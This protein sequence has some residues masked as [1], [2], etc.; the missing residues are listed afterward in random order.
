[1]RKLK[2]Q[3]Q[4][5][6]DGFVAGP[7]GELDWMTWEHSDDLIRFI[8]E[9]TDSV[10]T[11]LMGRKMTDGFVNYWTS[12]KLD[13]P[14]YDFAKKM[15]DKPKVV[16]SRTIKESNWI[17]TTVE[18][19]LVGTVTR[20]KE[21]DGSDIVVYGGAGF[22]SSLVKGNLID[23]YYLFVNPAAIGKGLQIFG[24]TAANMQLKLVDSTEYECGVVV[25]HY[26]PA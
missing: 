18:N 15:I 26:R 1:M 9:L 10:D 13:S 20:L 12:V 23:D 3:M 6:V 25:N 4:I 22:V 21:A 8:N 19:D 17:N 2:L 16:F 5:T 14:E 24:E 11:I 7:N